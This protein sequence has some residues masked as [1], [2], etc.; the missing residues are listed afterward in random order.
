I[1]CFIFTIV[2]AGEY[3]SFDPQGNKLWRAGAWMTVIVAGIAVFAAIELAIFNTAITLVA[4]IATYPLLTL[5][6]LLLIGPVLM[7]LGKLS[8][9]RSRQDAPQSDSSKQHS[10]LKG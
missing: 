7:V 10:S 5:I 9:S 1:A 4:L 3:V 8:W 2:F 6:G